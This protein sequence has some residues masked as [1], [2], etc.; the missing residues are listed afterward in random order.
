MVGEN[1]S[2]ECLG[3]SPIYVVNVLEVSNKEL[4]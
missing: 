3:L 1:W 2:R 4:Y